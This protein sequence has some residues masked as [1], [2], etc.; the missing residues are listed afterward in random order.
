MNELCLN[1]IVSR[2]SIRQ[3]S[4]RPV[5]EQVIEQILRAAMNAPSAN[6]QQPWQFIVVTKREKMVEI[7][8]FHPWSKMLLNAPVAILVV[9]DLDRV[10]SKGDMQDTWIQDCSAATQNAL[11]AAHAQGVGGVWLGLYPDDRRVEN[12]RK[13]FNIPEGKV[14][15]SIVSLGYPAEQPRVRDRYD[16]N[17]VHREQW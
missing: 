16:L 5:E 12:V 4:A 10:V 14:P 2:R 9:A 1:M 11:L 15:F 13:L 7:T 6:N 3:Y 8:K 17:R